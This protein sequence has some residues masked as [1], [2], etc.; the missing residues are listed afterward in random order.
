MSFASRLFMALQNRLSVALLL[1][2]WADIWFLLG[3]D[4]RSGATRKSKRL[5][6]LHG[7]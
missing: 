6:E 2:V 7:P 4:E 5:V 1:V 3:R